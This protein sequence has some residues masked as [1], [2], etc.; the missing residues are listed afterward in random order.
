[1][2]LSNDKLIVVKRG[3]VLFCLNTEKSFVQYLLDRDDTNNAALSLFVCQNLPRFTKQLL[4]G[5]VKLDDFVSNATA[6]Y[7]CG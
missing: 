5:T 3:L 6:D 1:M 4:N 7:I 2:K